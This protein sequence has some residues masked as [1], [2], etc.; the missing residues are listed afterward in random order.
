MKADFDAMDLRLKQWGAWCRAGSRDP[1]MWESDANTSA[2]MTRD[3][4]EDA[5]RVQCMV[6]RLPIE[7]RMV[8]QVHYVSRPQELATGYGEGRLQ[9]VNRRIRSAGVHRRLSNSE[10]FAVRD[11]AI[12]NLI[13]ADRL[14]NSL[15]SVSS[16]TNWPRILASKI[17]IKGLAA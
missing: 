9:E 15:K 13:N 2:G 17:S 1:S 3:Q 10:Y 12:G 16:A 14:T 7:M 8:C 4:I 6:M 5:W 11:R